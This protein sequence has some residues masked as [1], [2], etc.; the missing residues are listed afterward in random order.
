MLKK[1]FVVAVISLL[2]LLC[3]F[4]Q[5][6]ENAA[7]DAEN[8]LLCHRFRGL[9]SVDKNGAYRL[10][11]VDAELF[12]QGPHASVGCKDCHADIEK[13]PHND[14]KPVDCRSCHDVEEPTRQ[15]MLKHEKLLDS[16]HASIEPDGT[17]QAFQ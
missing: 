9:A 13:I 14:V 12:S 5:A 4:A 8:C 11:Y 17:P 3:H 10:F 7:A 16:V 1:S 6:V 2:L 15:T